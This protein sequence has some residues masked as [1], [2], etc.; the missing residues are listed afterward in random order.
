MPITI[1]TATAADSELIRELGVRIFADTFGPANTPANM[2]AYLGS[3]FSL[4]RVREEIEDPA[5]VHLIAE[6]D[7]M[8]V[9]YARL[10]AGD[11]PS[12]VADERSVELVRL[13]VERAHHGRGVAAALMRASLDHARD[14]GYDVMYLGVWQHNPRAVAFYS[15]WGFER[16]GEHTF[17][18]GEDEQT[19]WLMR[20]GV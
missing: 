18:L 5:S 3:A 15:K 20:R 1:R 17:M 16:F 11:A 13:Y 8:A 12:A 14:A 2:R 6:A 10:H 4:A 19:D 9:G 7:G